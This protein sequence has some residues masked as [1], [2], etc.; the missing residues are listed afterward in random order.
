M[1]PGKYAAQHPDRPAFIMASTGEAVTYREFEARTQPAGAPAARAWPGAAGPLRHLHGEQQPLPGSLLRRVSAPGCTSPA[2]TR[3]LTAGRAGLHRQ[4]Q[5]I[6]A[7]DHLARQAAGGG[8]GADVN[9]RGQAV[10]GGRRWR[11]PGARRSRTTPR[12]SRAYP[13]TPIADE[14]ARHGDAVFV[15]HHRPT[16]GHRAAAAGQPAVAS[17]CRCSISCSEL[18]RYREGMIYLSPAPL[19]HSAPQAAVSLTHPA[20]AAP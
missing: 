5:R 7:A 14:C 4:Q 2:S 17:R 11:G 18:W 12:P 1:Y 20:W 10:P 8:R 6:E 16:Q 15:G 19:Y 13:D 3:Y 9:A